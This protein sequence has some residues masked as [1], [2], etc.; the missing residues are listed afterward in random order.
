M[1]PADRPAIRPQLYNVPFG[2]DLC[3]ATARLVMEK[4]GHDPLQVSATTLLLPNN[5]AI[6]AM[7]EAFVRLAKPGLLLPRLVAIGDLALDESLGAMLDPLADDDIV[8]PSISPAAR[9][10]MLAQLVTHHRPTGHAISPAEAL[11]LARHLAEMIDEL[12]IEQVVPSA[13]ADISIEADLQS[14]WQSSYSQVL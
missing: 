14:H 7:T 8:L 10:I 6:K 11:R 3:E 9:I 12:E 4:C 2:T 13:L 1:P 5:R